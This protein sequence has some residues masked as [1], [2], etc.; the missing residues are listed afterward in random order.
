MN[1]AI[2]GCGYI[3]TAIAKIW[4]KQ[5]HRITATT[6]SPEMLDE[7]SKF[8]QRSVIVKGNDEE[9]LVPLIANNELILVTISAD[10]PEHYESAYLHT[11]QI[12]RRLGLEMNTPR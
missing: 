6:R 10:S 5:G 11:A 9:E 8:A 12:F 1:I 3:G 2:V 7:L 4:E